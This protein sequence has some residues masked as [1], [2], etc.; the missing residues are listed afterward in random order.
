MTPHHS[1]NVEG[2]TIQ[3]ESR[4]GFPLLASNSPV[5]RR[6]LLVDVLAWRRWYGVDAPPT[7][8][9]IVMT[10]ARVCHYTLLS[11]PCSVQ[12][13]IWNARALDFPSITTTQPFMY[14][15]PAVGD[16]WTICVQSC[17]HGRFPT[18]RREGY[19]VVGVEVFMLLELHDNSIRT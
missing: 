7:G 3:S 17:E 5:A 16:Y 11:S 2:Q 19:R 18:T 15:L 10:L 1:W 8:E 4:N 12:G 9:Q 13:A 6:W 14:A